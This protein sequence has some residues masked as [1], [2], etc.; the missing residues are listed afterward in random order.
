MDEQ[1]EW[2]ALQ[3]MWSSTDVGP[4]PDMDA[5]IAKVQNL[6]RRNWSMLAIEWLMAGGVAW[7]AFTRLP[8]GKLSTL[9]AACWIFTMLVML[10]LMS[11]TTWLRLRYLAEP[12]DASLRAWLA[13]RERRSQA[14]LRMVRVERIATLAL[15][16]VLVVLTLLAEPHASQWVNWLGYIVAPLMLAISWIWT[17]HRAARH[18]RELEDV[19]RLRAEWLD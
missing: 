13:I 17:G 3:D 8:F 11:R 6:A 7:M 18:R 5:M 10:V 9:Q 1:N 4:A 19:Q 16:P 14:E 2:S 15:A 12:A